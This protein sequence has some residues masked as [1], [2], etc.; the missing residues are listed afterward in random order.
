MACAAIVTAEPANAAVRNRASELHIGVIDL[1]DLSEGRTGQ[2][3]K[4]IVL[5]G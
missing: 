5:G 1:A 2:R 4:E 3:L